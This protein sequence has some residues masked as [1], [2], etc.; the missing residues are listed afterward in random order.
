MAAGPAE[1][2]KT[3]GLAGAAGLAKAAGLVKAA[4]L[5][6]AGGASLPSPSR[7]SPCPAP[8]WLPLIA[9]MARTPGP[10]PPGAPAISPATSRSVANPYGWGDRCQKRI[11]LSRI[12]QAFTGSRGAAG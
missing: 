10:A 9:T 12:K 6:R 7:P 4:G 3:V 8:R 5:A 2:A 11:V 1:A